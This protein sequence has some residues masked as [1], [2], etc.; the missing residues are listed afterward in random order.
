MNWL[1]NPN[2][3]W[4]NG[5]SFVRMFLGITL[6]YHGKEVFDQKQMADYG[7]WLTDLH[8]PVAGIMAYLGK[9]SEFVGGILLMLGLFTRLSCII[10][11]ITFLTIVFFMGHAQ[12]LMS[13]QHPFMYVILSLIYLF[14]GAGKLS[15]DKYY[16][17]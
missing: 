13:D 4:E 1:R 2:A 12:I 11:I 14:N 3:L 7:K 16:E 17:K 10:L 5:Y 15:L 9:G 6:I 8:F